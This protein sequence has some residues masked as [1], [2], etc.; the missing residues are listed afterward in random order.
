MAGNFGVRYWLNVDLKW[1]GFAAEKREYSKSNQI[2][3]RYATA[4][5]F[6]RV[7]LGSRLITHNGCEFLKSCTRLS[8]DDSVRVYWR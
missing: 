3:L 1:D 5:S 8:T 7:G 4:V 6:L 2:A